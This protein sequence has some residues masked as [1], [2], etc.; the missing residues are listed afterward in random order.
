MTRETTV[1]EEVGYDTWG[2]QIC[3]VE[4]ALVDSID[5]DLVDPTGFAVVLGDGDLVQEAEAEANWDREVRFERSESDTELPN[6]E[7]HVICHEC[8]DTIHSHPRDAARFTGEIPEEL[9]PGSPLVGV[10]RRTWLYVL[11]GIS[12]VIGLALLLL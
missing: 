8:A 5:E 9:A 11:I 10:G 2:C 7:G 3:G 12:A 4:V 1:T 6:V